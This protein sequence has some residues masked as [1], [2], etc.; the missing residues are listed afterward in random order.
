M[1]DNDSAKEVRDSVRGKKKANAERNN[2]EHKRSSREEI[3]LME[4]VLRAK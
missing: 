4:N 2:D 1:D 3:S